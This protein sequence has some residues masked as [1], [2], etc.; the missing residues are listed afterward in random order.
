MLQVRDVGKIYYADSGPRRLFNNLSFDLGRRERL[1]LLGRNGQGKSTL[2]KILGGVVAPTEGSV[3]WSMTASWPLG[4]AGGFQGGVT[5]Y[6]NI[7]FIA[8]IYNRPIEHTV[9]LVE[10]FAQLGRQLADPV[11]YYSSGMRAR[12]SFGLSLAIEFDCYLIDEVISVGDALFRDKCERELFNARAERAFVIASHDMAF[13]R[14]HCNKAVVID[15]GR[16]KVFDD[17]NLAIDI[18]ESLCD[19]GRHIG[20]PILND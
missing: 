10:E 6:D 20:A 15:A 12:L 11:K 5:G 4:F 3:K 9:A 13:L 14:E 8:R 18:Y 17:L 16:A 2:I 19:G 7:R 1:A